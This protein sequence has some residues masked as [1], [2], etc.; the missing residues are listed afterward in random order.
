LEWFIFF[1]SI[2]IVFSIRLIRQVAKSKHLLK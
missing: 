1:V 2:F